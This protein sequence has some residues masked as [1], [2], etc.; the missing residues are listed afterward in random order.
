MAEDDTAAQTSDCDSIVRR[1]QPL[2]TLAAA[3]RLPPVR[4]KAAPRQLPPVADPTST[5]P[6]R[7][8]TAPAMPAEMSTSLGTRSIARLKKMPNKERVRLSIRSIASVDEKLDDLAHLRDIARNTAVSVAIVLPLRSCLRLCDKMY[9]EGEPTM[10]LVLEFHRSEQADDPYAFRVGRQEYVR[11]TAGGGS[12][13]AILDWDDQL[14]QDLASVQ[15]PDCAPAIVQR[16]G[17]R[18]QRFLAQTEWPREAAELAAAVDRREPVRITLRMSA[19]ELYALPWELLTFKGRGEHIGALPGVTFHYECPDTQTAPEQPSPR[20]EGGRILLAWSAAGGAVPAAEH[21]AAIAKACSEG[22]YD[23]FD[24][25]TDVL[26]HTSVERLLEK[27]EA[28][29]NAESFSVLHILCHGSKRGSTFGL[30]LDGVDHGSVD[31][32]DG[33]RLR[34]VLSPHAAR[35][36]LV[37]L[38]ACNSG[39]DGEIGNQLG[40][41]AQALHRA[42]IQA[43]VASRFPLSVVGSVRLTAAL[44]MTLLGHPASLESAIMAARQRLL[45]MAGFDWASVQLYARDADGDDTRPVV[46]RPYRGLLAFHQEHR[47]FFFGRDREIAEVLTDLQALIDRKQARLVIV[48]GAS[49]TGKSSLVFA[50]AVPKLLA[51]NPELAILK[52]RP[53]NNPE[54]ALN[55][56]LAKRPAQTPALLVLDQFE[57]VFTQTLSPAERE[58]FVR[59]LWWLA[60][61]PET[62]LRIVITLRVDFIGRCGELVLDDSGLR[63]DRV[64]YDEAHRVFVAQMGPGELRATIEEPVVKAGL[65]LQAGLADRIVQDVGAEPGALPLLEDALD[66]LWQKRCGRTLT[67]S[68]Y[69][70]LGGVV[71]ALQN[72]ADAILKQLSQNDWALAQRLLI[73]LVAVADDT[74]LDS[75]LRISVAE[76]RQSVAAVDASGFERVLKAL[77]DARLLVLDDDKKSPTVE[78]THEALIRKWPTLRAWLDEDRAGL[79]VQ[80][81]V[82]QAAKLWDQQ[83]RDDS[84]LFRGA[85]LAQAAEW[86]K[87]WESRLGAME[88]NFLEASEALRIAMYRQ[89]EEQRRQERRRARQTRIAAVVLAVLF[90]GVVGAGVLARHKSIQ[91]AR[92]EAAAKQNA[93]KAAQNAKD[94]HAGLLLAVAQTHK[95]DPTFAA[96]LLREAA[97]HDSSVW[98]QAAVDAL[99]TGVAAT[100]L[101]GPE[102]R[103][104]SFSPNGQ[105][106]VISY[107]DESVVLLNT[108]G[109]GIPIA[110]KARGASDAKASDTILGPVADLTPA[111]AKSDA[112]SKVDVRAWNLDSAG[113]QFDRKMSKSD[114]VWVAFS[115]DGKTIV[116]RAAGG[117]LCT[118]DG[119]SG[120][121][122]SCK[123]SK[124]STW[125]ITLRDDFKKISTRPPVDLPPLSNA[126]GHCYPV[127]FDGAPP[128]VAFAISTD[129]KKLVASYSDNI[130]RVHNTDSSGAVVELKGHEELVVAVAISDDGRK[131]VTGSRDRTARVWNADGSGAPVVLRGHEHTVQ[132]VAISED[133]KKIVTGS[134]DKTARLWS[135]DGSSA[136]VRAMLTGQKGTIYFTSLSPNG[137]KIITVSRGSDEESARIWHVSGSAAPVVL[138]GHESSVSSVDISSDGKKVASASED[139]TVRIWSG[140]GSGAPVVIKAHPARVNAVAFSP[141]GKRLITHSA[142][143]IARIWNADGSGF[144][145][146]LDG[147][148]A[149]IHLVAWSR[150]GT[151]FVTGTDANT[152]HIWQADGSGPPV[153][154]DGHKRSVTA[155]A[156]SPDGKM[157][158]TGSLD[159]TARIWKADGSALPIVLRGHQHSVTFVAWSPDGKHVV[160]ASV[161]HMLRIW[162]AD[163]S[164]L[165][166]VLKGHQAYITFVAF[167]P[168]GTKLLS[169]SLDQTV[170]V[171]NTDGSGNELVLKGHEGSVLSAAFSPNGKK[172]VSGSLD[173]TARIWNVDG[174]GNAS[175]LKGHQSYVTAVAF[176]PDGTKIVTGSRDHTA[177]IWNADTA[178]P[179]TVL[180]GHKSFLTTVAFS[181]DGKKIVTGSGDHTARI[182][183]TDGS[184]SP[185]PLKGHKDIVTTVAFSMDGTRI[186]TG[187]VDRDVLVWNADG[188]GDPIVHRGTKW[189]FPS[190]ALSQDGTQVI[191]S[192]ADNEV[193]KGKYGP[194]GFE[195]EHKWALK[196]EAAITSL[197]LS[198]DGKKIVTG[199]ADHLARIWNADGSN[200]PLLFKGHGGRVNA[201]AFSFDGKKIVTGSVDHLARIWNADG[202]GTPLVFAGHGGYINAVAFSPDGRKIVTGSADHTARIWNADGTGA[203]LVLSGHQ[204]A[205]T[206]VAW[207]QDGRTIITGSADHTARIW[208]AD[209]SALPIILKG[210]QNWVT[211]VAFNPNGTKIVTGSGDRT[212]RIWNTDG[213]S[214]PIV[215]K[216]AKGQ[217]EWIHSVAFSPDGKKIFAGSSGRKIHD[218]SDGVHGQTIM[219]WN[220]NGTGTP[221]D[222]GPRAR[223]VI[224]RRGTL[225]LGVWDSMPQRVAHGWRDQFSNESLDAIYS[226]VWS[227]D[228]TRVATS[229]PHNT[230]TVWNA[231]GSG[232]PIVLEGHAREYGDGVHALAFSPDGKRIVTG[233]QDATPLIWNTDGSGQPLVLKRNRRHN[234]IYSVSWSPD[235]TKIATGSKDGIVRIWNADGSSEP[236]AVNGRGGAIHSIAWSPDG[237]RLATGAWDASVRLWNTDG[238]SASLLL[239]GHDSSVHSLAWSRDGKKLV[240]GSQ[241]RAVLVWLLTGD[242]L[243][244]A[245]WNATADCV[246]E[247]RRRDMLLESPAEAKRGHA[248]C[249]QE[250]ARQRSWFP[251]TKSL[252]R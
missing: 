2:Q 99:Q 130:T 104:Y 223:R 23:Y 20:P 205:I 70:A 189:Y 188:R 61:S 208:N 120:A 221:E 22:Y 24:P 112:N 66:V 55:D 171:W 35:L 64:A 218:G 145:V 243:L 60:S 74:A 95:D 180:E 212:A 123:N 33:G 39:N 32:V 59:H 18:I 56:A 196:H 126:G 5:A 90:V 19:A 102:I 230:A 152:A 135:V 202:S 137:D 21:Q 219:V 42:G 72:R 179:L 48:A 168:D 203:P 13:T 226:V 11:R 133:G 91:A 51:A 236:L 31:V 1:S 182:W 204:S 50:G 154:L 36:R 77:V 222:I 216:S 62:D 237:T 140:D 157:V 149:L 68:A 101:R 108:D 57:E 127:V 110:L 78:V 113:L 240:T 7:D 100:I 16:L 248:L 176:S 244:D 8:V 232:A 185:I 191:F 87:T 234:P 15:S 210:H 206:A 245:L 45:P 186:A 93:Q 162:N 184:G 84:L 233:A 73:S 3:S 178:T 111:E 141:D 85:Q 150:D 88:R 97:R 107:E 75:R 169:S 14:L 81:R 250:V 54:A 10:R 124:R 159:S 198:S 125:S 153:V 187:A 38:C 174:S 190:I 105:K 228:G 229:S 136:S 217:V 92:N 249:R 47:R 6:G 160:T 44:Y 41:V 177:R 227:P 79:V 122:I 213:S 197:A 142:D 199:S 231:D 224:I 148:Q 9:M 46:F 117:T 76:L 155:V 209:G 34:R 103:S 43:V 252:N 163:G 151:K 40:S 53:G 28:A 167:S 235:G 63:L 114:V 247:D 89:E 4:P 143:D 173:L 238:Y 132:S 82:R 94:A 165:P 195:V 183:N 175:V 119:G 239:L 58:V 115:T 241:D 193:K 37:V 200:A 96:V 17:D 27:L 109:S 52:M 156:F 207:S 131:I 166:I 164:G 128:P 158:V 215:L 138:S 192:E 121:P 172:I 106:I 146:V 134:A 144:P 12:E 201:V 129:G 194:T 211:A 242:L 118:W 170:R 246:P 25:S 147:H 139:K 49:G 67:Q 98:I 86:R 29:A 181:P 30:T 26:A 83:R 71:G 214:A 220:A 65:E 69:E 116:T 251:S 161:D 225:V 80:R